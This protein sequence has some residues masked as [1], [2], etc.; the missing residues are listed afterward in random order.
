VNRAA[1]HNCPNCGAE[2]SCRLAS[3]K[4]AACA[5]CESTILLDDEGMRKAGEAGTMAE[6]P[7]LIALGQEFTYDGQSF[8]PVGHARFSYPNGWWD[9]FWCLDGKGEGIWVSVDE[10]DIAIE[11]P[12]ELK[13]QPPLSVLKLGNTLKL[14]GATWRITEAD[15]GKCEALRGEFPEELRVGDTYQYWHLS[16]PDAR[17]LTLEYSDGEVSATEGSW[18]DPYILR[19]TGLGV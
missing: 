18:I 3:A 16:G 11:V 2:L 7:S 6:E 8:M 15:E 14:K 4:M 1:N 5:Y 9:E 13:K 10:G 12:I 19:S 17:L